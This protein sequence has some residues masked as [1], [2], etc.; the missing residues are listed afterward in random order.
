MIKINR[1]IAMTM[2]TQTI[3]YTSIKS[4]HTANVSH[5][6]CVFLCTVSKEPI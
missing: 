2:Y 1:S 3:N 5:F 4:E 6:L